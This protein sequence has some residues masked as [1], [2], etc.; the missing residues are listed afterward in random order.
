MSKKQNVPSRRYTD[1][2]KVEAVRLMDAVGVAEASRR[3]STSDGN[4]YKWRDKVRAGELALAD[5]K[6]VPIKA[7]PMDLAAENERLRRELANA[8]AD[9]DILKKA[10]AYFASLSR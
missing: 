6:V 4:L 2:F 1:E 8:K 7:G 3:L 9:I 5:G 10:S